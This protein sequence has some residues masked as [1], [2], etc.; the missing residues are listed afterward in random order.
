MTERVVM[1]TEPCFKS[2]TLLAVP[3]GLAPLVN[4]VDLEHLAP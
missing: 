3:L 1:L 2:G 4:C